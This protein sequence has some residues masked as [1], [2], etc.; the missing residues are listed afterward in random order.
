MPSSLGA[1]LWLLP[2][3]ASYHPRRPAPRQGPEGWVKVYG[4]PV[5]AVLT[6]IGMEVM[7]VKEEGPGQAGTRMEVDCRACM[8]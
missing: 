4:V 2:L 6:L 3:M 7:T 5:H 8:P 1:D